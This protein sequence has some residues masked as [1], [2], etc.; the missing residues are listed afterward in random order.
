M[1]IND[2]FMTLSC[3]ETGDGV[4]GRLAS[5]N[6]PAAVA[7]T[8]RESYYSP[9]VGRLNPLIWQNLNGNGRLF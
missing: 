6:A 1:T 9:L 5:N 4:I 8:P 3:F 7:L 2:F